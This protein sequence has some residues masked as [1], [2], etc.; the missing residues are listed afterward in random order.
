MKLKRIKER[1]GRFL[2]IWSRAIA[3]L[4]FAVVIFYLY[5]NFQD[6]SN[7]YA[8][9]RAIFALAVHYIDKIGGRW[10]IGIIFVIVA[11]LVLL[12]DYI[13]VKEK[14]KK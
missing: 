7:Q 14:E 8:G 12:N 13:E 9:K 3:I 11:A 6:P 5:P 10:L 4:L 2:D 1:F